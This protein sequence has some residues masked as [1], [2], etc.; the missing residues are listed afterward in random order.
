ML[1]WTENLSKTFAAVPAVYRA[2]HPWVSGGER[3]R[4]ARAEHMP[5]VAGVDKQKK[6]QQQYSFTNSNNNQTINNAAF[7]FVLRIVLLIGP[8]RLLGA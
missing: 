5:I 7:L 2:A 1:Y 6:N 8:K 3:A 4:S